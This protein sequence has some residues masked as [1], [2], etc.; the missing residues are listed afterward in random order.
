MEG[1]VEKEYY[2][3]VIFPFGGFWGNLM[4]IQEEIVP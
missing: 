1:I 2:W 4:N 3:V